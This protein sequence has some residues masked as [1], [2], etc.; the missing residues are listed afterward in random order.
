MGFRPPE[1]RCIA[2]SRN[3]PGQGV[4]MCDQHLRTVVILW[5]P[6]PSLWRS[7]ISRGVRG[8]GRNEMVADYVD[9][10][11]G[12]YHLKVKAGCCPL[13]FLELCCGEGGARARSAWEPV[14]SSL[15]TKVSRFEWE[16]DLYYYK[17]YLERGWLEV[18]KAWAF[19]SR[20]ERA[21]RGGLLLEENALGTPEVV[22]AG[23][24]GAECFAVTRAVAQG[25]RLGQYVRL[26]KTQADRR[27]QHAA[28]RIAEELGR[29]VGRMHGCGIAHGDLRWGNILVEEGPESLRFVLLDNEHT[30]GYRHVP[31]RRLLKNLIQLN[32]IPGLPV[33]R[34][35]VMRFWRAYRAENGALQGGHKRWA[36]QVIA[37]TARRLARRARKKHSLQ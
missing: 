9:C 5:Y 22:L 7:W 3:R 32:L 35:E 31:R 20:A 18:V 2:G 12:R 24:R 11:F 4:W 17:R 29:V 14:A 8:R 25:V 13:P 6:G 23:W 34:T 27:A 19:G 1:S 36:R 21:W 30:R 15:F 37:R 26:L 10:H 16:G 28:W 33:S